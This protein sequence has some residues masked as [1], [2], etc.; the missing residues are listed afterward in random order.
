M[1]CHIFLNNNI[2]KNCICTKD[3]SEGKLSSF[4]A[5]KSQDPDRLHPRLLKRNSVIK[6][7]HLI[8]SIEDNKLPEIWEKANVT[9][10]FKSGSKSEAYNYCPIS[11]T[12]V[13]GKIMEKLVRDELVNHI[14]VI[15]L[16]SDEQ[17]GFISRRSCINHSY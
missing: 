10:I 2:P 14:T 17:H 11:L 6:S 3:Y 16:F 15:N 4:N 1:N 8:K 7:N 9:V 13:P 12:S 5:L